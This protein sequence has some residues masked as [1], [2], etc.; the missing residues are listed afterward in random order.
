MCPVCYIPA[1]SA[2]AIWVLSYFGIEASHDNQHLLT[3]GISI[4]LAI[5]TY[6][7]VRWFYKRKTCKIKKEK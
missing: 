3:Y 2:F 5:I 6:F 7:V 1:L 4:I